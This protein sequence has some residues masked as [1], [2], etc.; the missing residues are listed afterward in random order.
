MGSGC[1]R[2][3]TRTEHRGRHWACESV[4]VHVEKCWGWAFS[5]RYIH[6]SDVASGHVSAEDYGG[7]SHCE[8]RYKAEK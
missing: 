8:C 4:M 7:Q 5:C 2:A 1:V 6:R 3:G